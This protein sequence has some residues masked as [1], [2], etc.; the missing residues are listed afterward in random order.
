MKQA[1]C[2]AGCLVMGGFYFAGL[3]GGDGNKWKRSDLEDKVITR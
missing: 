2:L 1:G 3:D